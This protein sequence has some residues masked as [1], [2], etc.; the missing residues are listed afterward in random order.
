MNREAI[1]T[2]IEKLDE[3]PG[4]LK[5]DATLGAFDLASWGASNEC[6]F[7]GCLVGWIAHERWLAD[8]GI[9]IEVARKHQ[10][11]S[12]RPR[13]FAEPR[14]VKMGDA[15]IV[16]STAYFVDEFAEALD[17]DT[18]T[19]RSL[20]YPDM[21]LVETPTPADVVA[22]LRLLLDEGEV[23]LERLVAEELRTLK[24]LSA[25]EENDEID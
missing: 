3:L 22:R 7:S 18:D 23:A 15:A 1:Q 25:C 2:M 13:S 16:G 9:E 24:E 11:T 20:I 19:V 6:G 5:A 12:G 21:Y 14:V 10:L 4:R 8:L 17:I